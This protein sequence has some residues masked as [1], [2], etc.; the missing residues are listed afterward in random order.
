MNLLLASISTQTLPSQILCQRGCVL[1]LISTD[2]WA[3]PWKKKTQILSVSMEP[4]ERVLTAFCPDYSCAATE[5]GS[6]Y[7]LCSHG[8][9]TQFLLQQM[10]GPVKQMSCTIC[11]VSSSWLGS[12]FDNFSFLKN[13]VSYYAP[14]MSG[15]PVP[16][17]ILK[18]LPWTH[19]NDWIQHCN[20]ICLTFPFCQQPPPWSIPQCACHILLGRF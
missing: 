6:E 9:W 10:R 13:I 4:E 11:K 12:D 20:C 2:F 14:R 3:G 1:C 8:N 16:M 7:L 18:Y 17:M 5:R 15:L 19:D